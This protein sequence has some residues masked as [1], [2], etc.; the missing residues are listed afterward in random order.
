M[1]KMLDRY[2]KITQR[3][4]SVKTE[5]AAGLATGLAMIY[6]VA[7]IPSILGTV[8][9][10]MAQNAAFTSVILVTVI[11]TL[12]MGLW[13]NVPVV[14]SVGL[15]LNA[16]FAFVVCGA[17]GFEPQVGLAA[18]LLEGI[19][20]FIVSVCGL[21]DIIVRAIPAGLKTGIAVSIGVFIALIGLVSGGVVVA[22]PSTIVSFA[23]FT[24][25]GP[26]L[27]TFI[28]L[29][30]IIVMHARKVPGGIIIAIA[31]TTLIG[32]PMGV[33]AIPQN[34]KAFSLPQAPNL[35]QFDF[36][37]LFT[38]RFALVFVTLAIANFFDAVG[39]LTSVLSISKLTNKEG[40]FPNIKQ[41]YVA[42]SL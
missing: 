1:I 19:L 2:F 42:D 34:F 9:G 21:R 25:P 22:H 13:A 15:G 14:V 5:L 32:I 7:V 18:I 23:D 39:T 40:N 29:I 3:G 12:I 33:T 24:S 35:F 30:L 41:A 4:S 31:L 38:A 37:Q 11:A 8:G 20:F 16:Y 26:A 10:V 17:M 36:S 6:I 27:L 28:G